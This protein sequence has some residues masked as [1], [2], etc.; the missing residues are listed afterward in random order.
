MVALKVIVGALLLSLGRK[1][2]WLFVAAIGFAAG[3]ALASRLFQNQSEWVLLLAALGF[4]V[5]GAVLAIFFQRLAIS[6]A[7]FVAGAL[8]VDALFK[9]AGSGNS[10][11]FY[12]LL[13]VGGIIGAVLVSVVFDWALILFVIGGRLALDRAVPEINRPGRNSCLAGIVPRGPFHSIRPDETGKT[14][15]QNVNPDCPPGS[16]H[17]RSPLYRICTGVGSRAKYRYR[18]LRR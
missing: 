5:I 12:V 1:I 14:L 9:A 3:L 8:I 18:P 2:Y 10:W 7:G 4:G 16:I 13:I 15:R 17:R 11:L 6:L